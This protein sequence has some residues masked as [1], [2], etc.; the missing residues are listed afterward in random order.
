MYTLNLIDNYK[1]Q[2]WLNINICQIQ[3]IVTC[4]INKTLFKK[5]HYNIAKL[6]SKLLTKIKSE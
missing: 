1:N 2:I 6:I 5:W 3:R 4:Y